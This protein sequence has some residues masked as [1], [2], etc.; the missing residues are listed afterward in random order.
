MS[1]TDGRHGS[2]HEVLEQTPLRDRRP[3]PVQL[4][5]RILA[6]IRDDG[7][8]PGDQ[9]PSEATLAERFQVGRSTVREALKLLERDGDVEVRHGSGSFVAALAKLRNERPITEFESVSEMMRGLGYTV[10]S[11]VLAVDERVASEEERVALVLP[12]HASVVA[13]ERLRLHDGFPFVFSRNVIPRDLL[14]VAPVDLDWSGS[15]LELLEAQG[16]RATSSVA[17]IR[18]VEA[19]EQL[20][21]LA[22][23]FAN[24]PWLLITE[25]CVTASGRA[26]VT[27]RDYHRGDVFTFHVVRHRVRA[28]PEPRQDG[29]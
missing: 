5:E 3:L 4:S 9:I 1:D 25:T 19:P 23:E 11:R 20:R 22:A 29:P 14:A 26:I 2:G 24:E 7:L 17:R 21:S 8:R 13:L 6:T 15:L 10:E 27:A 18:A 28:A 12:Q 16:H